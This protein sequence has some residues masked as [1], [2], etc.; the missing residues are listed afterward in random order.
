M[1]YKNAPAKLSPAPLVSM[2]SA[3]VGGVM[4]VNFSESSACRL[5]IQ[6][7]FAPSVTTA[8]SQW[9]INAL[10]AAFNCFLPVNRRASSLLQKMTSTP[11]PSISSNPSLP[12][13][14]RQDRQNSPQFW[15]DADLLVGEVC[16]SADESCLTWQDNLPKI[17]S[18][19]V[20]A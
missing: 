6:V 16:R 10:M 15:H 4:G 19:F 18:R 1:A 12:K 2:I 9:S 8:K 13:F 14:T 17:A 11:L 20:L 5:Q 3:T 7:S